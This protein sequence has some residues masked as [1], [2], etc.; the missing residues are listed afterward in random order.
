MA[1]T[2]KVL[3]LPDTTSQRGNWQVQ[4]SGRRVSTH[5]KKS[6]AR[7]RARRAAS[8]GDS[9]VIHRLDGTIQDR[10]TVRKG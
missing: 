4:V 3:P 8:D 2:V 6:A 1:K 9:M 10:K 5:L 7:R